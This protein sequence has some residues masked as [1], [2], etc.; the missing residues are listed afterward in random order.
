MEWVEI[1]KQDRL[2]YVVMNRIEKRNALNPQ[3]VAD[4]TEAYNQLNADDSVEIIVLKSKEGAFSAGAD[5][6]YIQE[7]SSYT[8]EQ[9]VEDSTRLKN[10]FE[11]IFNSP[12]VTIS[13]VEG[14]ALAG[15]CGLASI[16]DFCFATPEST[17]GYTEARIGFV[18][19]LVMVYLRQKMNLNLMSE[20][21][22]TASVFDAAKAHRDGLVYKVVDSNEIHDV[23]LGFSQKLIKGVSAQSVALTKQMMRKLPHQ[24]DEALSYAAEQNATARYSSDCK[25]GI[26]AFLNKEKLAW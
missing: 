11:L 7:L 17:F 14:P 1:E 22:L 18:P 15:G 10:L 16:T 2:A 4:L 21:L 26:A 24:R 3:L 8:H 5:L 6:A 20:W 23:V 19:A 25:K 12:K 9:N 13:L